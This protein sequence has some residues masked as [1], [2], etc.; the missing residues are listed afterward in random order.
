MWQG[1][2]AEGIAAPLMSDPRHPM[3]SRQGWAWR[4]HVG[5]GS[6]PW[7]P[8]VPSVHTQ[9]T[10]RCA[11]TNSAHTQHTCRHK[12]ASINMHIQH[13][14]NKCT[15]I[16]THAQIGIQKHKHTQ[17]SHLDLQKAQTHQHAPKSHITCVTHVH[18]HPQ[19][20]TAPFQTC[21]PSMQS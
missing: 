20:H 9:H 2:V 16:N 6:L 18:K 21:L 14:Q 8:R 1:L 7:T 19:I 5:N 12:H 3:S 11:S 13:T 15:S 17:H 4:P 10:H